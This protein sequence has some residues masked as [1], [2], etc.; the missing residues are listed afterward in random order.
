MLHAAISLKGVLTNNK[1]D[2][3][4]AAVRYFLLAY[5]PYTHIH[6][7]QLLAYIIF[8]QIW[9]SWFPEIANITKEMSRIPRDVHLANK[10]KHTSHMNTV[11]S[12]LEA[13]YG[14]CSQDKYPSLLEQTQTGINSILQH[15]EF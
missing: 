4:D 5:I 15:A 14:I 3:T 8:F 11:F 12:Y 13:A 10:Y 1:C 7:Q 2:A 9:L 6:M